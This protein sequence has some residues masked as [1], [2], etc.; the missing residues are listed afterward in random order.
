MSG[1][2]RNS[3]T[4]VAAGRLGQMCP[5]GVLGAWLL[6]LCAGLWG[7]PGALA[8]ELQLQGSA[9]MR[10]YMP[11]G[12]TQE[13][14]T[15]SFTMSVKGC[16]W[17]IRFVRDEGTNAAN[18][19]DYEEASFDGV[20][21]YYLCNFAKKLERQRKA[22]DKLDAP[23]VA[24]ARAYKGEVFHYRMAAEVGPIWLTYASGCYFASRTNDQV[25]PPMVFDGDGVMYGPAKHPK[26]HARWSLS[27]SR[28][29][30]PIRVTYLSG[31]EIQTARGVWKRPPP[32]DMGFTNSTYEVEAFT[33]SGGLMVPCRSCLK[34]FRMRAGATASADLAPFVEYQVRLTGV[35]HSIHVT[36]FQPEIP[37]VT[38]IEDARVGQLTYYAT[39]G[40]PEASMLQTGAYFVAVKRLNQGHPRP[41]PSPALV[42]ICLGILVLLP[43]GVYVGR[44]LLLRNSP[45][46]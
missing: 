6:G 36:S 40:W 37:G 11:S 43:V 3:R 27:D 23:N 44:R 32:Y 7:P 35:A 2:D 45:K 9:K 33:N 38:V 22:G 29:S 19:N 12:A 26:L 8:Q 39:N 13:Q 25:E 5:A 24:T 15:V 28:P 1:N 4:Q 20:N 17:M 10:M 21:V 31:G 46:T 14:S 18:A 42:R 16:N 41:E 30:F 34:I